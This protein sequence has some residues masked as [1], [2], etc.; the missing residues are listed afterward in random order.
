MNDKRSQIE[1]KIKQHLIEI[2]KLCAEYCPE[3]TY[4]TMWINA[5]EGKMTFHNTF[6]EHKS[7]GI[8]DATCSKEGGE[9][10]DLYSFR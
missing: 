1:E 7:E 8:I 6:W 2:E 4:L 5:T 3:D 9:W 10:G